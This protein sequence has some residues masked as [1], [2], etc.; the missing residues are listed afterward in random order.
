MLLR[1]G[2]GVALK[3]EDGD[4]RASPA[5]LVAILRDLAR[6]YEPD[7]AGALEA[8]SVERHARLAIYSTRGQVTGYLQVV[9]GLQHEAP[10][11][12]RTVKVE[13]R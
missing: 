6:R 10:V 11:G 4:M 8:P 3:V 1:S 9:G 12:V 2:I 7:L 13:A 5:A